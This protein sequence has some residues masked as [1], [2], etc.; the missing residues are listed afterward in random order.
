MAVAEPYG[1]QAAAGGCSHGAVVDVL[2]NAVVCG[3]ECATYALHVT[4]G[5]GF[6][7]V[8]GAGAVVRDLSLCGFIFDV[9][10]GW[11]DNGFF[12][13]SQP[14]LAAEIASAAVAGRSSFVPRPCQ[15]GSPTYII[16]ASPSS[17]SNSCDMA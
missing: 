14:S 16:E 3:P 11:K 13:T 7:E 17:I 9:A 5:A 15:G 1:L 6:E 10:G 4:A 12:S 2:G 8:T